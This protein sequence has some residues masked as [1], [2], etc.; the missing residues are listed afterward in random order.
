M[1]LRGYPN[2]SYYFEPRNQDGDC[3]VCFAGAV[4]VGTLGWEPSDGPY[5]GG[6]PRSLL[7][8]SS[9]YVCP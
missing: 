6:D 8:H 7:C 3:F 4:L 9:P 5:V 2:S 1:T